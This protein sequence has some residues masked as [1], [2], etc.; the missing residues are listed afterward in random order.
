MVH[1][2]H[3]G[4]PDAPRPRISDPQYQPRCV[5]DD[6]LETALALVTVRRPGIRNDELAP[7]DSLHSLTERRPEV[8][9][10]L[11][12]SRSAD[13]ASLCEGAS[14]CARTGHAAEN[15]ARHEAGAARVVVVEEAT[16]ELSGR[17]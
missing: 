4:R 1:L 3:P 2:P 13:R 6:V 7:L 16:D 10:L 14:A 9:G 11:D 8:H 15:S 5:P 12:R 17:E